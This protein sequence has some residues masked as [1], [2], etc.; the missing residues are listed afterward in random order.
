M[1]YTGLDLDINILGEFY[2]WY[3]G[4][5]PIEKNTMNLPAEHVY[6]IVYLI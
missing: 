6:R 5:V 4:T 2:R 1:Q 3:T